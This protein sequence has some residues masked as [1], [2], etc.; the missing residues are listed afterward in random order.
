MKMNRKMIIAIMASAM[1]LPAGTSSASDVNTGIF[2]TLNE[3]APRS[4]F[5]DLNASAP[6]SPFDEITTSSPKSI[7]EEIGE[8]APRAD[9]APVDGGHQAP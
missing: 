3:S 7:F 5:D 8:S 2:S 6:R 4:V 1:A 9:G